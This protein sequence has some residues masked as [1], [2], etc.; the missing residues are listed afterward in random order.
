MIKRG[1]IYWAD[2]DCKTSH[3]N[4]GCRPVLIVSNDKCNEFSPIVHCVPL[5]TK[6]KR[7]IPTHVITE[8]RGVY[9]TILCEQVMPINSSDIKENNFIAKLSRNEMDCVSIAMMKQFGI[10]GV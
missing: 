10:M 5:T 8:I 4:N 3:V 6:K 2:I 9:N 1:E 7:F